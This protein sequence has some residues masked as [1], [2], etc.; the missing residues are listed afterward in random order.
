MQKE[1]SMRWKNKSR[2]YEGVEVLLNELTNRHIPLA[3]LSNKPD[4]FT[5]NCATQLLSH[6]KF[7][8]FRREIVNIYLTVY[9]IFTQWKY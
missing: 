7:D 8:V 4:S 1:Y 5:Q 2:P 3:I 9:Y 6:W